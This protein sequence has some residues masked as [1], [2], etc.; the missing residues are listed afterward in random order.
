M[1]DLPSVVVKIMEL[2]DII[3][4]HWYVGPGNTY[5]SHEQWF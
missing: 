4:C 5:H 3:M 2:K 1:V